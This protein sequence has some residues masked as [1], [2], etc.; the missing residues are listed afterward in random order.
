[1]KNM[2]KLNSLNV[3]QG[4]IQVLYDVSLTIEKNELVAL[5][6]SNGAGKTTLLETIMG[7]LHPKSGSI[8]FNGSRID[9]LP[10]HKVVELGISIVPEGRMLFP[11]LSVLENLMLGAFTRSARKK[12]Q[13]NLERVFDVFPALKERK[14]Q[15]AGTLSGGEQQMLAI[16]RA[17][18]ANPTLLLLDEPSQGLAPIIVAKIFTLIK[19]INNWVTILIVEQNAHKALK[20]ASRVYILETGRIVR[21]GVS[22]ELLKDDSIRKAYLGV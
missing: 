16:G 4:N 9:H 22:Q 21:E 11:A 1:M 2:L 20:I 15:P 6:G 19:E 7:W 13:D 10:P 14:N 18:M 17:L 5:I 12:I 8:T 3:Y